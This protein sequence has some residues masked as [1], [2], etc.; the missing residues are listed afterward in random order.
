MLRTLLITNDLKIID[1]TPLSRTTDSDIKWFWVDFEA[2]SEEEADLLRTHFHFHPL[3][4]EDCFQFLQRPKLDHYEG[5]DFLVLQ[6]LNPNTL[7]P[8]EI[9]LFVGPNFLV[10]FHLSSS[11][12]TEFI[13]HE[14]GLK[15]TTLA[16][17]PRY[18][19]YL[20]TDKI[21]DDYFPS[22]YK[23]EDKLNQMDSSSER[24]N[25][26]EVLYNTRDELLTLRRTVVP[27]RELLYIL[28]NT[29]QLLISRE[30][31]LHF[32]DIDD[33]LL[34]LNEMIESNRE[35]TADMRD[36]YI[37]LNTNR[38]NTIMKTLTIVASIFIPL[39]FIVGIYGMNFDYMPELSWRWGY[40]ASLGIMGGIAVGM[41]MGFW[42][43]GWFK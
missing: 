20:L 7:T 29:E 11:P 25:F 35:I 19:V 6:S 1:D 14:L 21:V 37:S 23:I 33:H 12:E 2:P 15:T 4:I 41:L 28:L 3:A 18:L 43:K 38:M 13:R 16:Q 9:D 39:T 17:G 22:M 34:K 32:K 8:E 27:M 26:I 5:Y 24:S 30:E 10:T 31:R 42:I 36:S 40:F